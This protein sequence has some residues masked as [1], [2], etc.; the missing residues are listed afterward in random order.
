MFSTIRPTD[1]P[2]QM[3]AGPDRASL[4]L[5]FGSLG[6][7]AF[8]APRGLWIPVLLL[9]LVRFKTLKSIARRDYWRILSKNVPYLILPAYAV[10]SAAW[11][12]VPANAAIT[13]A[14]LLGYFMAAMAVVVVVDRLSDAERRSVLIWGAAGL[15]I[16]ELVVWVDL[17]TAGAISGLVKPA[18]FT[19]NYYSRG[20]AV[21]ACA[22]LPIAVGLFRL[23]GSR[24][25]VGFA[26]ICGATVFVLDNEASKVAAVVG[27]LVYVVVRWRG[28]LFWP[29]ILF[30]L[31]LG[32]MSPAFF[33]N[34]LDNGLLCTVFNVKPSAAHRLMIYEFSSRRIF[35][36]PFLGWGMDASR[37]IP[38]GKDVAR[39]FDC[40]YRDGPP[41]NQEGGS[42]LPLHPHSASL[43][44]WLELGAVGV[45]LF[46]GL[47]GVLV[48]R[49]QR[50]YASADGRALIAGLFT[51]IFLVYNIGFGLWQGWLIF[52]L[53]SLCAILRALPTG[54][55]VPEGAPS[56]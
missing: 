22:V 16:V 24:L 45:A 29:A 3:P 10:L 23:A 33:A 32:I 55:S 41:R 26:G 5:I 7:L 47:L 52:A 44:V 34:G 31:A 56:G 25:A 51:A 53:I 42:L 35:E 8:I 21:S 18:P 12:L 36:K 54:G 2:E 11:A 20:A 4:I 40:G 6:P 1:K 17:A 48:P 38:G 28:I 19:T 14:K 15:V 49:L 37:S 43:Q 50:R 39:I 46:T 30:P 9:L 13:G 27:I